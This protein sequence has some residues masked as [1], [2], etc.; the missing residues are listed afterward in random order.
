[1]FSFVYIQNARIHSSSVY[2]ISEKEK[3]NS[4]YRH[5]LTLN[6]KKKTRKENECFINAIML[7]A[8]VCMN[9]MSLKWEKR[10]NQ[11]RKKPIY[12]IYIYEIIIIKKK[13]EKQEMKRKTVMRQQEGKTK[14]KRSA[15]FKLNEQKQST[16]VYVCRKRNYWPFV[17]FRNHLYRSCTVKKKE[18]WNE[19]RLIYW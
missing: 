12:M 9:V 15:F 17:C 4:P 6:V 19:K 3:K 1:M 10:E 18:M 14:N 5:T 13:N 11:R 16:R 7:S 2:S 8:R